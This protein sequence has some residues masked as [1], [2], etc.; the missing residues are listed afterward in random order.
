[1]LWC[2]AD[3]Q[4]PFLC[5]KVFQLLTF[6]KCFST[7]S[8]AQIQRQAGWPRKKDIH[9]HHL[10][11]GSIIHSVM[12]LLYFCANFACRVFFVFFVFFYVDTLALFAS[13]GQKKNTSSFLRVFF[14]VHFT[15]E[16]DAR[17]EFLTFICHLHWCDAR[18]NRYTENRL[19]CEMGDISSS[20]VS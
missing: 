3:K 13:S 5:F 8:A 10:S 19:V 20:S 12:D 17:A 14:D 1:M 7:V 18:E 4:A 16:T 2:A 6:M 15:V 9:T 11:L